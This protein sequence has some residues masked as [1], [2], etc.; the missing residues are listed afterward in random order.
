MRQIL[1]RFYG[2]SPVGACRTT[3][4]CRA[5]LS[6]CF[7]R[8]RC[9]LRMRDMPW[10]SPWT[11]NLLSSCARRE[12]DH[13]GQRADSAEGTCGRDRT[14]RRQASQSRELDGSLP[15]PDADGASGW[16]ARRG[17]DVCS[18][19]DCTRTQ[20]SPPCTR[21]VG[22]HEQFSGE[23]GRKSVSRSRLGPF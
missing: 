15:F 5:R 2:A 11:P 19:M 20:R 16:T 1:S 3:L 7:G 23:N 6:S 12:P 4:S 22:G 9:T 18:E 17:K 13:F 10:G 8:S 14:D 21:L